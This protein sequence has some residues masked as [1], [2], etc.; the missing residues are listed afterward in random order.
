MDLKQSH[1]IS[2]RGTYSEVRAIN[3]TL[4]DEQKTDCKMHMIIKI[5][6]MRQ[7]G[8]WLIISHKITTQSKSDL[9]CQSYLTFT[10]N[11]ASA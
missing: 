11:Q 8:T 7:F 4:G 10:H 2:C 1:Y 3:C 5:S 9:S 6:N